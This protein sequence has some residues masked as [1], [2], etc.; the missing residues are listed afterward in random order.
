MPTTAAS[1]ASEAA[2]PDT[3]SGEADSSRREPALVK[4]VPAATKPP[5]SAAAKAQSAPTSAT[6]D[7]ARTA[8]A[9]MRIK[10]C[11][12]SQAALTPGIL[13]ATNSTRYSAPAAASTIGD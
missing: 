11:T 1:P 5:A 7:A 8:P 12:A 10:V 13:S 2:Q 6:D 9:G 3:G 4:C